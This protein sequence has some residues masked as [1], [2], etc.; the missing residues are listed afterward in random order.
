M[1]VMLDGISL[2]PNN[3]LGRRIWNF[4]CNVYEIGDGYD[5]ESLNAFGI[6]DVQNDYEEKDINSAIDQED[7]DEE[8]SLIR[9]TITVLGQEYEISS[10]SS[11]ETLKVVDNLIVQKIKDLYQGIGQNYKYKTGS[12]QLHDLKIHFTSSPK[13]FDLDTAI[14]D[15][16][17]GSYTICTFEP[18]S[19]SLEYALSSC[20]YS[21]PS[22]S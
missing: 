10:G 1:I 4:S 3:Q 7:D 11:D 18:F 20:S 9:Q 6:F 5:L 16:S 2:T 22:T 21:T 8:D 14:L 13:Y 19:N 17:S 12:A 15:G